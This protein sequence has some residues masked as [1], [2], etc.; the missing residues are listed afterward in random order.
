MIFFC[1]GHQASALT[2]AQ[3]RSTTGIV[4]G[5]RDGCIIAIYIHRTC[6]LRFCHVSCPRPILFDVVEIVE[7][8]LSKRNADALVFRPFPRLCS[9]LTTTT[10]VASA[11]APRSLTHCGVALIAA[12]TEAASETTTHGSGIGCEQAT[13]GVADMLTVPKHVPLLCGRVLETGLWGSV[14]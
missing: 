13:V 6:R 9:T 3:E 11:L 2:A 10:L 5:L 4:S 8:A 1:Q 7:S 14:M 12:T